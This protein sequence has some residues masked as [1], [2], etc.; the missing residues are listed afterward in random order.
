MPRKTLT[1]R[2]PSGHTLK[3]SWDGADVVTTVAGVHFVGGSQGRAFQVAPAGAHDFACEFL[4]P[5]RT[6]A[7]S[8]VRGMELRVSVANDGSSTF[9]SLLGRHHELMTVFSG[10]APQIRTISELFSVLDIKDSP[11]GMTV[12]PQRATGLTVA[13]EHM[14]VTTNDSMSMDVPAPAYAEQLLPRKRGQRTRRG[15]VWRNKLP[16]RRGNRAHDYSY[17]VGTPSG[18]AEVQFADPTVISEDQAM[19]VLDSIDVTWS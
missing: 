9:A 1:R 12:V 4:T 10:P 2:I 7:R 16:G 5:A 17:L 13:G 11:H 18:I 6:V 3:A 8:R 15:E 19:A 14:V